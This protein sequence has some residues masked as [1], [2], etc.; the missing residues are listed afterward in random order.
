MEE[1]GGSGGVAATVY[2]VY[3]RQYVVEHVCLLMSLAGATECAQTH[4]H[5]KRCRYED[6]GT[7]KQND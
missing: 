5:N 4:T 7:G 2:S 1:R 3:M 6:G